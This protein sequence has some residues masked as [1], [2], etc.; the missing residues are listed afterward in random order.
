RLDVV[1]TNTVLAGA[2]HERVHALL[3]GIEEVAYVAE[4]AAPS[5]LVPPGDGIATL[6]RDREE[7]VGGFARWVKQLARADDVRELDRIALVVRQPLPYVYV[8]REVLR[9][10]GVPCQ[11]FDALPLAAEPYAAALDL[12]FSFVVG[13]FARMPSVALL[14]S[15]H[16]R[17]GV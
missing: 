16:F 2:F 12:V 11:M 4:S 1:V 14:R 3:P 17:F 7:E 5:L 10:A 8:A 13:N 6:A 15:P 9:A